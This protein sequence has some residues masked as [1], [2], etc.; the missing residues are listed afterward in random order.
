MSSIEV[1]GFNIVS[2]EI[3]VN[4]IEID[5][6]FRTIDE[7]NEWEV[8]DAAKM[9]YLNKLGDWENT[10]LEI[11]GE[12][13][14]KKS[15]KALAI[16]H[17]MWTNN[18]SYV[19]LKLDKDS[20]SVDKKIFSK[21]VTLDRSLYSSK[22]VVIIK[23]LN[24]ELTIGVS[25]EFTL[26]VDNREKPDIESGLFH[27]EDAQFKE[28][29]EG[30]WA[31][32]VKTYGGELFFSSIK[33]PEHDSKLTIYYNVDFPGINT[34]WLDEANLKGTKGTFLKLFS[35][36]LA[37]GGFISECVD[38]TFY[39]HEQFT[40]ERE[41]RAYTNSDEFK[42]NLFEKLEDDFS[43]EVLKHN[44]I[45]I[46]QIASTVFPLKTLDEKDRV[47][48]WWKLSNSEDMYTLLEMFH[49]AFQFVF[50]PAKTYGET[51][52]ELSLIQDEEEKADE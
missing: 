16:I 42:N 22:V 34:A 4:L 30:D 38:I 15:N 47:F 43:D 33:Q 23:F 35:N 20:S 21:Q 39:L 1:D 26:F 2:G 8:H 52:K 29:K 9:G 14:S 7:H 5:G 12:I 41:E 51:I 27:F 49:M 25:P 36:Y 50:D 28:D 13:E 3:D 40:E 31:D 18:T 10:T 45:K 19:E 32:Y 46:S 37:S 24:E 48:E 17:C 6:R 44:P 11:I